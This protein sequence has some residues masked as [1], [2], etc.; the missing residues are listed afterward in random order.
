MIVR[1]AEDNS[2]AA[3]QAVA[4]GKTS[5]TIKGLKAGKQVKVFVRPLRKVGDTVNAGIMARAKS[6]VKIAGKT[7]TTARTQAVLTTVAP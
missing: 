6:L 4:A 3:I 7:S 2:K 1:Y 5:V